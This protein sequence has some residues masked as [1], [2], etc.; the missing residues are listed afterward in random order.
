MAKKKALGIPDS[1]YKK[2]MNQSAPNAPDATDM[3]EGR[4][5]A[6]ARSAGKDNSGE[7]FKYR[8]STNVVKQAQEVP[9]ARKKAFEIQEGENLSRLPKE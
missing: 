9:G 1:T 3:P 7:H 8:F 5:N 2:S 4:P 6:G